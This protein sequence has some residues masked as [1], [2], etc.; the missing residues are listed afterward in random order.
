[1]KRVALAG[2]LLVAAWMFYPMLGTDFWALDDHEL[3]SLLR[4][5]RSRL[6]IVDA[7]QALVTKTEVGQIFSSV[8][9]RPTYYVLRVTEL[10][11]WHLNPHLWF[12]VRFCMVL[13]SFALLVHLAIR[14]VGPLCGGLLGLIALTPVYWGDT[15]GRTGP[16]EQ[17]ATFG[18]ALFCVGGARLCA[19]AAIRGQPAWDRPATHTE[20]AGRRFASPGA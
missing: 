12:L 11:F 9:F 2:T 19:G 5:G 7:V 20:R 1:M 17:Y 10:Y 14:Y 6:G 13:V 3:I 8:R 4:D 16:A 18:V 15:W